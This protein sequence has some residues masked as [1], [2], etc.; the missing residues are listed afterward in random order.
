MN[1]WILVFTS[2]LLI[3]GLIGCNQGKTEDGGESAEAKKE[4][5]LVTDAAYAPFEY[6]EGDEIVGF[7]I[8]FIKA[9]AEEA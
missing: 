4:L 8:D 5:R 1:R 2:L 7:D 6:M 9:V 3:G